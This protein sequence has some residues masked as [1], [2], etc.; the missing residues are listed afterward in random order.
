MLRLG[1]RTT[2]GNIFGQ[3]NEN[4][5]KTSAMQHVDNFLPVLFS[6]IETSQA[7]ESEILHT[8][9]Y[10]DQRHIYIC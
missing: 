10:E 4:R 9:S 8:G 3:E 6:R 2:G 5:L 1:P 7:R